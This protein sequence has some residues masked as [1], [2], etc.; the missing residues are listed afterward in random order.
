MTHFVKS[1]NLTH[2]AIQRVHYSVKKYLA[3]TKQL[4]FKWRQ[5]FAQKDETDIITHMMPF[6][7]YTAALTCG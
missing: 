1:A 4:E 2:A 3:R 6:Q 5:T 7:G